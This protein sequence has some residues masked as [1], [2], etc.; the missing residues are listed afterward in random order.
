MQVKALRDHQNPYGADYVKKE[1]DVYDVPD[2]AA[3]MLIEAKLVEEH[4]AEPK[5]TKK[6]SAEG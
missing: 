1:G 5:A 6:A 2:N 4:K 3:A